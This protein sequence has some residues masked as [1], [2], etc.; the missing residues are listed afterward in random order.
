MTEMGRFITLEGGEGTGKSTLIAGL[1]RALTARGLG[2][3]ITREPGGTVLAESIRA[4]A[5][6][7]PEGEAWS[8]MA[9]ALLMNASREDHLKQLIRPAI[10]NGD[11]VLCDRFADSTR[12]YQGIDGVDPEHLLQIETIV[13]GATIPDLTIVLDAAPEALAE[14]R[15]QR[16]VSDV[17]EKKAIEFH[18]KVR[19]A[20]LEIAE[21]EPNRCVVL[22]ALQSPEMVL[23]QAL[24]SIDLRLGR[25]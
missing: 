21:L 2:T 17:F 8:P 19:T 16:D 9:H 12:A 15:R 14:R 24:D 18:E 13:V 23:D 4:L 11:W 25:I 7:P 1:H 10:A 3:I 20:F 5:L 6:N 22:D